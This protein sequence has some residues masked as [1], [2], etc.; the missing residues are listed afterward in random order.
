MRDRGSCVLVEHVDLL[1]ECVRMVK[2]KRPFEIV[3]WV[4]LPDHMHVI[5]RLPEDDSDFLASVAVN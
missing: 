4:V 1:R 3:A 5:W 2:F